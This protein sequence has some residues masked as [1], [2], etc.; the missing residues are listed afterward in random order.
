MVG[1]DSSG[2]KE[3][4]FYFQH[5]VCKIKNAD[6]CSGNG[7]GNGLTTCLYYLCNVYIVNFCDNHTF[8]FLSNVA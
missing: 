3:K 6:V 4:N 5:Q 1:S 7:S 8:F 2:T